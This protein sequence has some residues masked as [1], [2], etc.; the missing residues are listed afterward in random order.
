M[1]LRRRTLALFVAACLLGLATSAAAQNCGYP[2]DPRTNT[3]GYA[4]WCSC[5]GGSYNYQTTECVGAHGP[6]GP[7]GPSRPSGTWGCLAQARNGAWGNSWGYASESEA[8]QRANAECRSRSRGQACAISYCRTGTSASQP[9]RPGGRA[10]AQTSPAPRRAAYS[11]ALCERKLRADLESGWASGR[12]RSYV[13][14]AIVGY[15]NCKLK[16]SGSCSAG[17][18]LVRTIRNGCSGFQAETPFRQCVGRALG[19]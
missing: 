16:A 5:M 18:L 10:P 15:Q 17:D 2:P 12:T 9:P 7:S 6:R 8:R 19:H 4:A 1:A 14:Q 3:A 13:E 11:C